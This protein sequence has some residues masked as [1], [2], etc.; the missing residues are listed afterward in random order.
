MRDTR[1]EHAERGEL[2][3]PLDQRLAFDELDPQR[4]DHFAVND[5]CRPGRE[6]HQR[7]ERSEDDGLEQRKR[8]LCRSDE[9]A[10]RLAVG[11]RELQPE[12]D[13]PLIGGLDFELIEGGCAGSNLT[14]GSEI[15][16]VGRID[17]AENRLLFRRGEHGFLLID[18]RVQPPA[19]VLKT[20]PVLGAAAVRIFEQARV[21]FEQ[22]CL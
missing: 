18:P 19:F 6:Q 8:L 15:A 2:F 21:E 16:V 12:T 20:A 9:T 1:G 22:S 10:K 13:Q 4:R 17:F 11:V 14:G 3:V 5:G 7:Q